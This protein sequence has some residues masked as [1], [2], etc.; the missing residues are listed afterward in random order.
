MDGGRCVPLAGVF[1]VEMY[2]FILGTELGR[3]CPTDL[4]ACTHPT[5]KLTNTKKQQSVHF[6]FVQYNETVIERQI[7]CT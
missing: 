5:A 2:E 3:E 4:E 1:M 7:T 6:R